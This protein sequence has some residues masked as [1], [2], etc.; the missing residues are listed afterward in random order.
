MKRFNYSKISIVLIV[1]AATTVFG[2]SD[3]TKFNFG[4]PV[5]LDPNINTLLE[6]GAPVVSADGCTIY[7]YTVRRDG[8][9]DAEICVATRVSKDSAWG[10]AV[11]IG[12]TVNTQYDE[13]PVSISVDGLSLY[14]HSNKPG[15]QGKGDIRVTTRATTSSPWGTPVNLGAT[16]NSSSD[17]LGAFISSDGLSLYFASDRSNGYGSFDLF[18]TTRATTSSSWNTP[19]N[20]GD[21]VNSSSSDY[22]PSISTDGLSLFFTSLRPGGYGTFDIYVTTRTSVSDPWGPPVNLGPKINSPSE[23]GSPNI[24]TD[25]STLYFMSNGHGG[26]GFFDIF[27]APIFSVPTCGDLDHPYPVGDFNMDCRVDVYDFL[28]FIDHWLDCTAPECDD[29]L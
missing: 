11:N 28:I 19:V 12:S 24:S 25:G 6:E 3:S 1:F 21:T 27:E 5:N 10:P 22:A 7:F 16:V 20:L 4:D 26:H 29:V 8:D 23:D 9:G 17:D 13:I 15:G 14:F 2:S 18:V